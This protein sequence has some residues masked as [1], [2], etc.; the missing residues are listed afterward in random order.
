LL[1]GVRRIRKGLE[2]EGAG[3]ALQEHEAGEGGSWP[4]LDRGPGEAEASI[5]R[6]E[7]R[8]AAE[9]VGHV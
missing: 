8:V 3:E 4:G 2:V 6:T 7:G 1:T 5:Q 9:K